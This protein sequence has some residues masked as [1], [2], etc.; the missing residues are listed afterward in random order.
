MGG[1]GE[2]ITPGFNSLGE[3]IPYS[4]NKQPGEKI[5]TIQERG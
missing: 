1:G 5:A 2:T 4:F 3:G